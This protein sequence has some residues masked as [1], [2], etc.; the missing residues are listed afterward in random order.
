MK[1]K[2]VRSILL[3]SLLTLVVGNNVKASEEEVERKILINNVLSGTDDFFSSM[4]NAISNMD[5][6][7]S[8][9]EDVLSRKND[10]HSSMNDARSS[11][12]DAYSYAETLKE[13]IDGLI[14]HMNESQVDES[15]VHELINGKISK[16]EP[17]EKIQKA[18]IED[19]LSRWKNFGPSPQR[20]DYPVKLEK[21]IKSLKSLFGGRGEK[22]QKHILLLKD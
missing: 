1:E 3:F 20:A 19:F 16:K 10:A 9:M 22:R 12:N 14:N 2:Y 13:A 17:K 21:E 7:I 4:H 11:M 18:A 15:Q 8:S 5:N 6:A